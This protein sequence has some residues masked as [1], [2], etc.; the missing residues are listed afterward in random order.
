MEGGR[1]LAFT[2]A[3]DVIAAAKAAR[4][5]GYRRLEVHSPFPLHGIDEVLRAKQP[6]L[7]YAAV[8]GAAVG[9]GA[10]LW[11]A[12][13]M[14]AIDYPFMISGKPMFS[15]L[16]SLPVAFE[17]AILLAA[18]AVFGGTILMGGL[19]RPANRLFQI[20]AFARATNDRFFLAID[21]EDEQFEQQA[22]SAIAE[23]AGAVRVDTIPIIE[24][25]QSRLP[26][27]FVM[28]AVVLSVLALIPPVLIAKARTTTSTLPRISIVSDMDHQPKFKAQ[29]TSDLFADGRSMRP[30][31]AGSI[32]RGDLQDDSEYYRGLQS[33]DS[34]DV[35]DHALGRTASSQSLLLDSDKA[36]SSQPLLT[37]FAE[38][39]TGQE[40][41]VNW[42]KEFP[43]AVD[44]QLIK[45]GQER[46]EIFC[47][48]CHGIG[49][50]GDGLVTLRALELEQGTW[51]KPTSL[52]AEP[53]RQQPVGQLY[54]T[55]SNGVR[56]MPGYASQ[57]AV[58][59]RWA[60]VS[61]LR[62]LQK[63]RTAT[64]DDVPADIV[65]TMRELN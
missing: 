52:H 37:T 27:P 55:I 39:A 42:I 22:I 34:R 48:T 51:V 3:E 60:I 31:V 19:P 25:G 64:I 7:P 41:L 43:L 35:A 65:P 40:A 54:N 59:D 28:V 21:A 50:D 53:V 61:Y 6:P 15:L 16:P 62:A 4:S 18:F 14:N 44:E 58:R 5:A 57:I 24:S 30:Q 32:A 23:D 29:T 49:G 38:P 26:R 46:Y 45:R 33:N 20:P 8:L 10:G 17:L 56:K 9:L 1:L 11:M 47:A 36:R 2:T 13:W 12:W 63:T